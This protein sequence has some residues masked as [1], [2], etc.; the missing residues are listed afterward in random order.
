MW[1]VG[2]FSRDKGDYIDVWM[3]KVT[4]SLFYS[5]HFPFDMDVCLFQKDLHPI[6]TKLY[7][8]KTFISRKKFWHNLPSN[9][10]INQEWPK[11]CKIGPTI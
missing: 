9:K 1:V 5:P 3:I 4:I 7:G 6:K 10:E 8:E 11:E 2:L